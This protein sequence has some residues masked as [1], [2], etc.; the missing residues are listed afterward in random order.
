LGNLVEN[1]LRYAPPNDSVELTV[2]R[3]HAMLVFRVADRG[4]GI[5]DAERER[6]FEPFY[7]PPGA[8]PDI[9][10]AGLG[11]TIARGLAMAQ[12]GDVRFVPRSG[13]G[14]VFELRL[15]AVDEPPTPDAPDA[16]A[17]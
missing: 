10:G 8:P 3:E 16:P 6:I 11:L 5:S 1:A 12:G 17:P 4:P 14:S 7:R 15:P 9:G 13:G 2:Q